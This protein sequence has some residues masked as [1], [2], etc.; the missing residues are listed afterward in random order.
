MNKRSWLAFI[1]SFNDSSTI[2]NLINP[3]KYSPNW[4]ERH[5]QDISVLAVAQLDLFR[6]E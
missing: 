1:K 5:V 6:K 4:F 2:A 3:S